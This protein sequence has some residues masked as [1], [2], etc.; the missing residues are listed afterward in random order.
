ML[1]WTNLASLMCTNLHWPVRIPSYANSDLAQPSH[2]PVSSKKV[3]R[4]IPAS[5]DG[6]YYHSA[7][8][9]SGAAVWETQHPDY[10]CRLQRA[11]YVV[12]SGVVELEKAQA[13]EEWY[14]QEACPEIPNFSYDR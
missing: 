12:P 3:S 7:H 8:A 1:S 5:W 9:A 14:A 6:C 2:P 11:G 4:R 10:M 13:P